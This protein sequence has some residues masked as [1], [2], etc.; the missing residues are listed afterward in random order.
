M[1]EAEI[2]SAMAPCGDVGQELGSLLR[3]PSPADPQP[4]GTLGAEPRP[5]SH[6]PRSGDWQPRTGGWQPHRLADRQPPGG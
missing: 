4:A 1:G 6:E 5:R 2:L 3:N